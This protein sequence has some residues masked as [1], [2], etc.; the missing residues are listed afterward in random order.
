MAG[1]TAIIDA[2]VLRVQWDSYMPMAA[3]CSHHSITK[4]QLIGLKVAFQLPPRNDRRR[5]YKPP[6]APKPG[7]AEELASQSSLR[8]AP[9]IADRVTVVHAM[10]TEEV[11][12]SRQV[13]RETPFSL[14]H[15]RL[16]DLVER[17]LAD[18]NDAATI[19]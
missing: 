1:N 17:F 6:R 2:A 9:Q 3:I 14:R 12:I 15:I 4:D 18:E 19:E 5:R 16:D 11:R 8:L 7:D 10:W 13:S